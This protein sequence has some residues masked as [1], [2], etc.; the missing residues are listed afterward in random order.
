MAIQTIALLCAHFLAT[1]VSSSVLLTLVIFI[2]SSVGGYMLHPTN[3]TP[4]WSWLEVASPQKWTTP[5]LAA[6]EFS[7]ETLRTT[8]TVECKNKQ[9]I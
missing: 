7:K 5:I 4:Y 9:V 1:K 2:L 3:I 8:V 6:Y